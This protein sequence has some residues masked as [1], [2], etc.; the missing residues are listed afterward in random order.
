MKIKLFFFFFFFFL[1]AESQQI[2]TIDAS[3][4]QIKKIDDSLKL[5]ASVVAK[6]SVDITS[7]VSEKIK[8]FYLKK[9]NL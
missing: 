5:P 7:V 8:K 3:K 6:E 4:P 2:V 1:K 9:E